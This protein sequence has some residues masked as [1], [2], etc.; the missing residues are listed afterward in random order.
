M[1]GFLRRLTTIGFRRGVGGSRPWLYA[2]VVAFGL[3]TLRNM[4]NPGPDV[5][6]RTRVRPGE[7]FE[8]TT[9]VPP[10]RRARR[11]ARRA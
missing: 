2:A 1:E 10:T 5:L 4:A 6:Y 11:K 7:R 3:R 8:I 9:R